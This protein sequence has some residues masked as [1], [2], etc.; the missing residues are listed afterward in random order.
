MNIQDMII[1][2]IQHITASDKLHR[3]RMPISYDEMLELIA[4]S[5][6]LT[7]RLKL[8][9]DHTP[10]KATILGVEIYVPQ[11]EGEPCD[12]CQSRDRTWMCAREIN[13]YSKND[14]D[15]RL[16]MVTRRCNRCGF[17]MAN[18]VMLQTRDAEIVYWGNDRV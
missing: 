5:A 12:K 4:V 7:P 8:K 1:R 6:T 15:P 2:R 9:D 10:F 14:D 11:E 17:G 18:H 3:N 16:F 13:P